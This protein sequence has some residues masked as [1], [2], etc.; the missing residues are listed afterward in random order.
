[1]GWPEGLVTDTAEALLAPVA[2]PR[3]RLIEALVELS[4]VDDGLPTIAPLLTELMCSVANAGGAAVAVVDG[5]EFVFIASTGLL[6][7][8]SGNRNT[9]EG[10]LAGLVIA[11]AKAQVCSDTHSDTRVDRDA[12]DRDG[13]RSLAIMPIRSADHTLAFVLLAAAEPNGLSD[14]DVELVDPLLRLAT[15]KIA[16][17]E[18]AAAAAERFRLMELTASA[19]RDVLLADHPGQCLVESIATVMGAPHVYLMLPDGE[20]G[21]ILSHSIGCAL[22]EL[23]VAADESSVAGSTYL[24]GRSHF[25]NDWTTSPRV[26]GGILERMHEA[27]VDDTRSAVLIPLETAHG[28][29]GV[30]TVMMREPLTAANAD[31]LGLL[32]LLAAEAG[33]AISRENLRLHLADQARSDPLTGLGNRRVWD[34]R[35]SLECERA[36]RRQCPL[37]IAMLDLDLFKDYND[38]FGHL[39]G[40]EL[41]RETS[42]AWSSTLRATDL[43]ARL[44]GEEFGVILPDTDLSTAQG[45]LARLGAQV[46]SGQ[47]VSIGLTAHRPG[48]DQTG[49]VQR[50]DQALY[51]AK[52]AGR[53]QVVT[54]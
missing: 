46:P 42:Q 37:A 27:N 11:T 36:K 44:G 15:I 35:L 48:E 7:G 29:A 10:S 12:C 33:V 53:N 23:R 18:M 31:R 19:S 14:A 52:S 2:D 45:I 28:P 43:I 17:S 21:L 13:V 25:V 9:R 38:S 1:M 32:R 47:T 6:A 40:D 30:V 8:T 3:S 49:T 16:Q 34:E 24:S 50:A 41:L 20:G 51:A 39:A 5:A 26:A 54:R 22:G 4:A